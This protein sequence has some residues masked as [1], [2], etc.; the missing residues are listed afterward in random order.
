M[1]KSIIINKL[2]PDYKDDY[3][4][5]IEIPLSEPDGEMIIEGVNMYWSPDNLKSFNTEEKESPK[6]NSEVEDNLLNIL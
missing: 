3:K 1:S 2:I 6:N 5:D 4:D